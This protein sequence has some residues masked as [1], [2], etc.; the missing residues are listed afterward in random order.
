MKPRW[1]IFS[2]AV[3]FLVANFLIAIVTQSKG[4]AISIPWLFIGYYALKSSLTEL[5]IWTGVGI[6]LRFIGMAVLIS[7]RENYDPIAIKI[8][9]IYVVVETLILFLIYVNV[10]KL[11]KQVRD[12]GEELAKKNETSSRTPALNLDT[13]L[14]GSQNHFETSS[15]SIARQVR[16]SSERHI[17]ENYPHLA[18]LAATL[19]LDISVKGQVLEDKIDTS[20]EAYSIAC[21][22]FPE[23]KAAVDRIKLFSPDLSKK[24]KDDLLLSK[25]FNNINYISIKYVEDYLRKVLVDE[26]YYEFGNLLYQKNKLKTLCEYIKTVAI[27]GQSLEIS[28][29]RENFLP[30]PIKLSESDIAEIYSYSLANPIVANQKYL[31]LLKNG[32]VIGKIEN[33]Y[34]AFKNIAEYERY[35]STPRSSYGKD[36]KKSYMN[37]SLNLIDHRNIEFYSSYLK[38]L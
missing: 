8:G 3:L 17:R 32:N 33:A 22:F 12:L 23:Y 34:F 29:L 37:Y 4:M 7:L 28:E 21:S 38:E 1:V 19:P 6:A 31:I 15:E 24:M 16:E 27:I 30:N 10:E 9:V 13:P 35:S 11:I 26:K 14:N 36:V 5:R 20:D 2:V 18:P 25:D